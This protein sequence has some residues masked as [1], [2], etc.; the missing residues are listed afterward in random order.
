M[1]F[2]HEKGKKTVETIGEALEAGCQVLLTD[3]GTL[4]T[5]RY[6]GLDPQIG[7]EVVRLIKRL[8]SE[9]FLLREAMTIVILPTQNSIAVS[10]E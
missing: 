3:R 5:L 10:A 2:G 8:Y 1:S 6:Q 4:S 7:S 9:K